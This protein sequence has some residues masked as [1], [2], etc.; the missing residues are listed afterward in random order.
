MNRPDF[1][2]QTSP[3]RGT[4]R[5]TRAKA[6]TQSRARRV[7]DLMR[8]GNHSQKVML[9]SLESQL[10]SRFRNVQTIE[11]LLS[12]NPYPST[13][14]FKSRRNCRP[15][16]IRLPVTGIIAIPLIVGHSVESR[17]SSAKKK[18]LRTK[19][20][21]SFPLPSSTLRPLKLTFVHQRVDKIMFTE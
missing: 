9:A 3:G 20:P 17:L 10:C 5:R 15:R 18:G 2:D 7:C 16:L 21:V 12:C 11:L 4:N 19:G 13:A 8:F 1:S 14:Q 6:I